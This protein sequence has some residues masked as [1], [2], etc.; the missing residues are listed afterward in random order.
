MNCKNCKNEIRNNYIKLRN[1]LSSNDVIEKSGVIVD[2]IAG[3][4]QYKSAEII[5]AYMDFNNEVKT[6]EFL[7]KCISDG[8]RIAL[9]RVVDLNDMIALEVKD[10]ENDLEPGK[11]GISEPKAHKCSVV[12]PEDIDLVIIPG[13]VFDTNKS[14]LGYG[15]GYYD[16]FLINIKS[17]CIKIA[18]AF[19][20]Q[21]ADCLPSLP[22]D[23]KMDMII[24]EN[25]VI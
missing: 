25:R 5:M 18:F 11:Y 14:R 21:I 7:K 23:I 8:K 16:R 15:N 6:Y 24:T 10:L 1:K 13:I 9:P 3:L 4:S 2:K 12:N 17:N 19:D 22:H 20:M